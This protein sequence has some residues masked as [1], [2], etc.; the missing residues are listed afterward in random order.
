MSAD[1]E[2]LFFFSRYF[3]KEN[4]ACLQMKAAD[5]ANSTFFCLLLL[6]LAAKSASSAY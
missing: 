4:S 6:I 2:Y 3:N 5:G 1:I